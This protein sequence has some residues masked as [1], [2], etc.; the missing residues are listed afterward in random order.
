M[1]DKPDT[2]E[3]T[4]P[5]SQFKLREARGKGMVAK[6][7][8]FN[9]IILTGAALLLLLAVGETQVARFVYLSRDILVEAGRLDFDSASLMTW[10]ASNIKKMLVILSPLF[11]VLILFS[12]LASLIQ[13][14]PV[15]SFF[16]LKPDVSRINPATGFKR[17]FSVKL[18]FEVVKSVIKLSLLSSIAY[19][20][21]HKMIPKLLKMIDQPVQSYVS[22]TI[23]Y[24]VS[25]G[26]TL[27]IGIA[28]IVA[29]DMLFV[30]WDFSKNM[31][32]TKKEV[33]DEYKRH[34]G[35]PLIKS[36]RKEFANELRKRGQSLQNVKDADVVITNP[37]RF[38]VIL[39]YERGVM[40]APKV[41][42]KGAGEMAKR[43]K[44]L[45]YQHGVPVIEDR[46]LARL[47]FRKAKIDN[48]IPDVCFIQVAKIYKKIYLL[49]KQVK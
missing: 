38:A 46:Q 32:M 47:I 45:A 11:S 6:S 8:E 30:R 27:L 18:L 13:T 23:H 5:A 3:Q 39:K 29:F 33:K 19:F 31:R 43:I 10:L 34:E 28:V 20:A 1:A 48:F 15:F 9:S 14:G 25:L 26:A 2:S 22:T 42:G 7:I 36:K 35:D 44:A 12:I 17:I 24:T 16:M 37:T 40:I 21:L 4:E 41:V 49:K